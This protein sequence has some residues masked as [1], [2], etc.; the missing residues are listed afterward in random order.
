MPEAKGIL[1][2]PLIH[3]CEQEL[4]W[5]PSAWERG[6]T[7]YGKPSSHPSVETPHHQTQEL[8]TGYM[9]DQAAKRQSS[10]ASLVSKACQDFSNLLQLFQALLW[11]LQHHTQPSP[12]TP[13]ALPRK[14]RSCKW[15]GEEHRDKGGWQRLLLRA[16]PGGASPKVY[17]MLFRGC[18]MPSTNRRIPPCPVQLQ[19]SD[20]L[21][22]QAKCIFARHCEKHNCKK[23]TSG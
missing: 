19:R 4:G 6:T 13:S 5:V 20:P 3:S 21:G 23:R 17:P 14:P 2:A 9:E 8:P 15:I 10:L 16:L 22:R 12:G 18:P 11:P 7:N 1:I